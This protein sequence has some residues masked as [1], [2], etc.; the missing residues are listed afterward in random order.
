[1]GEQDERGLALSV[2]E[3]AAHA[4]SGRHSAAL[5]I[6]Q[7]SSARQ[8]K[9]SQPHRRRDRSPL[10]VVRAGCKPVG[11]QPRGAPPGAALGMVDERWQAVSQPGSP[12]RKLPHA[13]CAP[14]GRVVIQPLTRGSLRSPLATRTPRLRRSG[15]RAAHEVSGQIAA[16]TIIDRTIFDSRRYSRARCGRGWR[17]WLTQHS[18]RSRESPALDLTG[19]LTSRTGRYRTGET[20]AS[21]HVE[22][23]PLR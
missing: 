5:A 13:N 22:Q 4:V 12:N 19:I 3:R 17:P 8:Q 2:T 21:G 7:S 11:V 18:R 15:Q 20:T 16:T 23:L 1:M 9:D 6:T 10:V 14:T